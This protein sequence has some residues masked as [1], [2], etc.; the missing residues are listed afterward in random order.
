MVPRTGAKK[1]STSWRST[2]RGST[3]SLKVAVTLVPT[4]TERDVGAGVRWVTVGGMSSTALVWK[5][6][7]TQ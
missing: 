3:G 2:V 1:L 5:R 4:A 6:T 7:S